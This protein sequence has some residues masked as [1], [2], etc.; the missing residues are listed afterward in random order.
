LVFL[1]GVQLTYR[2]VEGK[3]RWG[4]SDRNFLLSGVLPT[5]P[6]QVVISID[7]YGAILDREGVWNGSFP[8]LLTQAYSTATKIAP[9]DLTGKMGLYGPSG[10][11]IERV[12]SMVINNFTGWAW[13]IIPQGT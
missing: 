2:Q 5:V 9:C 8:I 3:Y 7:A 4:N 1:E 6:C 12:S 10:L 13:E 11:S